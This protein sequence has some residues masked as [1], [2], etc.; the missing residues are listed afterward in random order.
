MSSHRVLCITKKD[1]QNIHERITNI[2]G[3]NGDGKNWSL[4]QQE[5]IAGIERGEWSFYVLNDGVK[6]DVEV[7]TNSGH[8]YLKTNADRQPQDNLLSLPECV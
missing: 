5:A 1:R 6:A 7:A 3:R 8:K 4:T 2:G